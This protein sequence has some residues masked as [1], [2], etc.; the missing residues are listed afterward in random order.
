MTAASGA[1]HRSEAS[2]ACLLQRAKEAV[3]L[4][5]ILLSHRVFPSVIMYIT[6]NRRSLTRANECH[7]PWPCAISRCAVVSLI[8]V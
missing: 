2:I 6:F 4:Y 8:D 3:I 5:T 7:T 1:L